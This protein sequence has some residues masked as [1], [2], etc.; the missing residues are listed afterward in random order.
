MNIWINVVFA[1]VLSVFAGVE[2]KE[3]L[4]HCYIL[5]KKGRPCYDGRNTNETEMYYVSI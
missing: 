4:L 5:E 3:K 1:D 2:K